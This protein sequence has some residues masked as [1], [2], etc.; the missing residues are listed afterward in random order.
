MIPFHVLEQVNSETLALIRA[1]GRQHGRP[2]TFEIP[3]NL[4]R[5][6][7]PKS[8][9]GIISVDEQGLPGAGDAEGRRQP[10]RLARQGRQRL[11]RLGE[12]S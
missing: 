12:I 6:Q 10:M 2:S 7:S 4:M 1:N 11:G 3:R 8:Y 5:M 9:V